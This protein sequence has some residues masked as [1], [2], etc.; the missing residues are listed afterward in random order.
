[1][2]ARAW[3]RI[4]LW[5]LAGGFLAGAG[6]LGVAYGLG[7]LRW[8]RQYMAGNDNVWNAQLTWAGWI[9]ASAV[10]FGGWAG[11]WAARHHLRRNLAIGG[12]ILS[13][14]AGAVGAAVVVP[15]AFLR[16]RLPEP[17]VVAHPGRQAALAA[18]LGLAVG[19]LVAVVV[20]SLGPVAGNVVAT[21]A[22][23]WLAAFVSLGRGSDAP[24]LAVLDVGSLMVTML[25]ITAVVAAA[26]AAVARWAGANRY[27]VGA[28]GAGG[29]ALVAAAYL[30]GGTGISED[31]S[32][33]LAPFM[34]ALVAVAVGVGVS[35]AV[36][37]VR[38]PARRPPEEPADEPEELAGEPEPVTAMLPA[39]RERMPADRDQPSLGG[40]ARKS[41]DDVRKS[42]DK[43]SLGGDL[44]KGGDQEPVGGER[45]VRLA[46]A[47]PQDDEYLDWLKGL[48]DEPPSGSR[49]A[50]GRS[51]PPKRS[52]S[53]DFGD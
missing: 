35:V 28:S 18:A 21:A 43:A 47:R 15:L 36:A 52:D 45:T 9:A 33:Q 40:E 51:E 23:V 20:L 37:V 2:A 3:S 46:A 39:V 44:P 27:A 4:L 49:T 32:D 11:V 13:A 22:W 42:R 53:D 7:I 10:I 25:L 50:R 14:L 34:S 17:A 31:H 30:I 1:M 8:D 41:R 38:K 29:P 26:I 19:V 5:A 24:R 12:R 16:A 48:S 6:Q